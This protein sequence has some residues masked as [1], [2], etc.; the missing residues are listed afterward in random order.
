VPHRVVLVRHGETEWST[1][2]RHTGRTDVP[3]SAAGRRR[4]EALRPVLPALVPEIVHS[5]VATSPLQRAR[6]TG[7]LAGFGDRAEVWPELAE[8]DYGVF[9]GRTTADIR[10]TTPGWSVWTHPIDGGESLADVAARVDRVI[11]RVVAI[12]RPALL[13]A[14]AHLLRILGA[15][16][17]GL[18]PAAARALTIDPAGISILG[19]EHEYQVIERW[20]LATIFPMS[21]HGSASS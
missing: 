4:A 16:W 17:C 7:A 14:H 9:E 15:R 19:W 6:D 21:E 18:V 5:F 10:E 11:A 2:R 12:D 8:W 20:N 13:F 1:T 3:L